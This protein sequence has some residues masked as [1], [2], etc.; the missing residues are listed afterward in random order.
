MVEVL[1]FLLQGTVVGV[2]NLDSCVSCIVMPI[3]TVHTWRQAV[4]SL[5]CNED[6]MCPVSVCWF[7]I[8]ILFG[9]DHGNV[10]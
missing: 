10:A 6:S 4:A 8:L 7:L 1:R 5:V 2:C 9:V 3:G